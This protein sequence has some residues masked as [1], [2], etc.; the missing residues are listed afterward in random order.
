MSEIAKRTLLKIKKQGQIYDLFAKSNA[1]NVEC[2]DATGN[3]STLKDILTDIFT[4]LDSSAGN[5]NA[6]DATIKNLQIQVNNIIENS[7]TEALN[8]L[9]EI[10]AWITEH[11]D[12]YSVLAQLVEGLPQ[13]KTVSEYVEERYCR[14]QNCFNGRDFF[15]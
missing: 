15:F 2:V 7:D 5:E 11:K 8:S 3:K 10:A 6:L 9:K 12:E 1:R 4:K 14:N 13:N